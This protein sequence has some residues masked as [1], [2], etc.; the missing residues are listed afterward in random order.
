MPVASAPTIGAGWQIQYSD[1]P[2]F[3]STPFGVG[4]VIMKRGGKD[5][6]VTAGSDPTASDVADW[7]FQGKI[8][9]IVCNDKGGGANTGVDSCTFVT[10]GIPKVGGTAAIV[11]STVETPT[12]SIDLSTL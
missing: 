10:L 6:R 8:K 11:N 4:R 7:D 5:A 12:E 1:S 3:R 2:E 9:K